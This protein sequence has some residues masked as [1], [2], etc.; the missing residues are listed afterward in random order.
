MILTYFLLGMFA[1]AV[2]LGAARLGRWLGVMD[3]PDG[4][5]KVHPG[6]VPMVGGFA[7][8]IPVVLMA[9][10]QG[11]TTALAP[12]YATLALLTAVFLVLGLVDDRAQVRPTWRL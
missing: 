4:V 1:L 6:P 10:Y 7:V 9:A 5:R 3:L 12:F 8:T 11:A 2:C